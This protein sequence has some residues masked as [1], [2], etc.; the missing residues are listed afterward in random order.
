M[1]RMTPQLLPPSRLRRSRTTPRRAQ[2]KAPPIRTSSTTRTLLA[3]RSTRRTSPRISSVTRMTP[4]SNRR[5]QCRLRRRKVPWRWPTIRSRPSSRV[6]WVRPTSGS[7]RSAWSRP[8]RR[9]PSTRFIAHSLMWIPPKRRT[10]G[11]STSLTPPQR[12]RPTTNSA[13]T[14]RSRT[15]RCIPSAAPA[16]CW[17]KPSWRPRKWRTRI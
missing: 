3:A 16:S 14:P 2:L 15:R 6:P 12:R 5:P 10:G 11:S 17:A 8:R 13:R 4:S 7:V 9:L 1:V